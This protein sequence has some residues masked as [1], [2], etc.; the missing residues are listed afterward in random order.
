MACRG[1]LFALTP[2]DE[3]GL[4]ELANPKQGFIASLLGK[5]PSVDECDR[6]VLEFLINDIEERWD[7][8]WFCETD[9]AWDAIHRCLSDGS[10]NYRF[11]Q[12]SQG[13]ILGGVPLYSGDDYV[14]SYKSAESVKR[15]AAAIALISDDDM[16]ARYDALDEE[17]YGFP[18]DEDDRAYTIEWF[19]GV[20]EFYGKV[21]LAGRPVVFSVDQ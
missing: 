11:D 8:D 18:K 15:I 2:D 1:V 17:R 13:A 4:L 21:A 14:I 6:K 7:K 3:S 10:L 5:R 16:G 20:R 9:K 19:S 12:P